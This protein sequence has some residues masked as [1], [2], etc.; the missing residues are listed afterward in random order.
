MDYSG[1]NKHEID[2]VA[3]QAQEYYKAAPV[4]ILGSGASAAF[5]LSG[6]AALAKHLVSTVDVSEEDGEG[7]AAWDAFCAMLVSGIDLESALLKITLSDETTSKVVL[8]TWK[9]LNPEDLTVF[10][11]SMGNNHL[12]PLGKLIRHFLAS[13]QSQVNIITSNYDRLAE[14]ACEQEGIHHYTGFSYGFKRHSVARDFLTAKRQVNIWKVHGSLDWFS[15]ATGGIVC[16]GNS[17]MIPE[18]LVPLIVTPGLAKFRNTHR[19]PYK[20]VIHEADN[21]LDIAN[22]YLC[23]G[24]GFNDEHVQEKLINRCSINAARVVVITYSLS[25]SA[26]S[27]LFKGNVEN[28]LAI[29]R[30]ATDDSSIIYS[31]NFE[32]PITLNLD[33]WTLKG[34]M[35]LLM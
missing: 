6:M 15:T 30:G 2:V 1:M 22:A 7:R 19:E 23:I 17:N 8:A 10:Y 14:Y 32:T 28:Y 20:S 3:K 13:T 33:L 4:I 5:G 29:E 12:F 34:F 11:A 21:I 26:R 35:T 16:L 31:S 9:L 25:D 18:G 27:F 24:F